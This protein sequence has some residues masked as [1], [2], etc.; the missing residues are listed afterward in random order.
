[1][2]ILAKLASWWQFDGDLTD[3]HG[4]NDFVTGVV[5]AGYSA[6]KTGQKLDIA[7]RARV[8]LANPVAIG[9]GSGRFAYGGW[10]NFDAGVSNGYVG[11]LCF[12]AATNTPEAF[13]C[14][15]TLAGQMQVAGWDDAGGLAQ[16]IV[17]D[18]GVRKTAYPVTFR[19]QD[20]RGQ[21]ASSSQ[22]I[23]ISEGGTNPAGTYFFVAVWDQGQMKIYMDSV[24]VGTAT[25][26]GAVKAAT[27]PLFQLGM[28]ASIGDVLS[29]AGFEDWFLMD[30]SVPTQAEIDWL[31]N[32]GLGRE[33]ADLLA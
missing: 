27:I 1:M 32:G 25:A 9:I 13:Y 7:S 26:T 6:G 22:V 10:I 33:Y 29:A 28:H 5:E 30:A 18:D 19:I 31:Y 20:S 3:S 11:G 14:G 12:D 21:T 4:T 2:T 8:T 24:L 16:N 23:R 17:S 15:V